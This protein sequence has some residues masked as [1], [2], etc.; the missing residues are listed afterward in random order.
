[1]MQNHQLEQYL[2]LKELL[3]KC[4]VLFGELKSDLL[5]EWLLVQRLPFD[6]LYYCGNKQTIY[7]SYG[8]HQ[9]KLL[10]IFTLEV[11]PIRQE[12]E[13]W[14]KFALTRTS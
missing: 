9:K 4:F 8:S 12:V 6:S 13:V 1:M 3:T 14:R 7:I 2:S 10:G 11:V 5:I